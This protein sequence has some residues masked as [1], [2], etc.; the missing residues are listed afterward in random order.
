M[1]APEPG[2]IRRFFAARLGGILTGALP[3]VEPKI[4][5]F[6]CT[7]QVCARQVRAEDCASAASYALRAL[8]CCDVM[9]IT[10]KL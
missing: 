3:L 4:P 1:G 10:C 7:W 9:Q 2:S 6:L 5:P 8:S